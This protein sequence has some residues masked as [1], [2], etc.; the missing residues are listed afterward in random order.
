[1]F[2]KK[3]EEPHNKAKTG[4]SKMVS[5]TRLPKFQHKCTVRSETKNQEFPLCASSR[6]RHNVVG[7]ETIHPEQ[8]ATQKGCL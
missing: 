3:M 4:V 2:P 6:V 5:L 1:M 7:T 8:K